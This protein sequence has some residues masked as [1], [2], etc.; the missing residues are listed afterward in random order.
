MISIFLKF[1]KQKRKTLI[2]FIGFLI[3]KS[4]THKADK[5][6]IHFNIS[7]INQYS[8]YFYL[9][10]KFFQIEGYQV[11]IE[12]KFSNYKKIIEGE[13]YLKYLID[14]K[15]ISFCSKKKNTL[16]E[17]N[18]S[19]LS[20]AYFNFLL[21]KKSNSSNEF[22]IPIA[23]HP[24][25]YN[26]NTWSKPIGNSKSNH[27][28]FMAGNFNSALYGNSN[29]KHF[30]VLSRTTI[31]QILHQRSAL[32]AIESIDELDRMLVQEVKRQCIIVNA[33]K[34]RIPINTLRIYLNQFTFFMAC[35]GVVMPY[36]HNIAEAMSAGCIP[37]IQKE[38]AEMMHPPL[39]DKVNAIFFHSANDLTDSL[40]SA[41][42]LSE[43]AIADMQKNVLNY[44]NNHLTPKAVVNKLLSNSFQ[45]YFLL[46]EQ[47]SVNLFEKGKY[48]LD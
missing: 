7:Q 46:A 25:F 26:R 19:N 38:Y 8:R 32:T 27:S 40:Q 43:A 44:Y 24:I 34:C 29:E 11:S 31:Y 6:F 3:N 33:E 2:Q 13:I 1:L 21:E 45:K 28:V 16:K 37:L 10:V 17:F 20:P 18:D 48:N 15:T 47:T 30:K 9:L 42:N 14:E 36:C 22:F 35:P 39:T 41:Y 23:M 12:R 5:P 4:Q